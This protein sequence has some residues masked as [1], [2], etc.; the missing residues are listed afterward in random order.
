MPVFTG[1]AEAEATVTLY[2]G[3]T[4]IGMGNADTLGAWSIKTD[5]LT[6][7]K[8]TIRAKVTDTA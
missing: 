7:G 6:E 1:M 5:G 2:D 8:H 4:V 3:A